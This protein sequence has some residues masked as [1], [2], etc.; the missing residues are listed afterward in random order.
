MPKPSK[1]G[2]LVSIGIAFTSLPV[3]F[4]LVAALFDGKLE[5]TW[6]SLALWVDS[7]LED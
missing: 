7:I 1:L 3:A 4:L 2:Y 6:N 5:Q